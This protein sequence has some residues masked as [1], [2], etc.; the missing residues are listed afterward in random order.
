M[1]NE[2]D[3]D[4]IVSLCGSNTITTTSAITVNQ[5]GMTLCC[6]SED[7]VVE[8]T[9]DD[10]N[11]L[12]T[13]DNFTLS[14]VDF[15]GGNTQEG[16]GGGNV[17]ILANGTHAILECTFDGGRHQFSGGNLFIRTS[18]SVLI[19]NSLFL[20][21]DAQAGGG[22]YVEDA[23]QVVVTDS[24]FSN[25][26]AMSTGG[27]GILTT[28]AIPRSIGQS[29]TLYN[30]SFRENT[31]SFGGGYLQ[32]GIGELPK[33]TILESQ[34]EDNEA[35]EGA[36]AGIFL[37]NELDTLDLTLCGNGGSGNVAENACDDMLFYLEDVNRSCIGVK[38]DF[39]SSSV[40]ERETTT[41][42]PTETNTTTNGARE[43][44]TTIQTGTDTTPTGG[45]E[46]TISTSNSGGTITST[47]DGN[48]TSTRTEKSKSATTTT[49]F[50]GVSSATSG[51]SNSTTGTT[52][53][54]GLRGST[55]T[56]NSGGEPTTTALRGSTTTSPSSDSLSLGTSV[57]SSRFVNTRARVAGVFG[58]PHIVTFD[59]LKF[60]CQA[61]GQFVMLKSLE[62][63]FQIQEKFT[64]VNTT[65]AQASVS[66]GFVVKADDMPLI[67][68]SLLREDG[69]FTN[70][71]GCH[72]ILRQ[73]RSVLSLLVKNES[74]TEP[75][76]GGAFI[77]MDID[78]NEVGVE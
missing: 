55:T 58:D 44:S 74:F 31:A 66:T 75:I 77:N 6:E 20:N 70:I 19:Q 61:E 28:L 23:L 42:D 48:T 49:G 25:N 43:A 5:T 24:V 41:A 36:A 14:N 40:S 26:T 27:G 78:E 10:R 22:L 50:R 53:T 59:G 30:T 29:I 54:T 8:S 64:S 4:S 37:Y 1:V 3:S 51:E 33:L 76:F 16:R 21:G 15:R 63:D 35:F 9:G 69:G 57:S 46:T 13:G 56:T 62:S 73:D 67:E 34:F 45:T 72:V 39:N 2:A 18:D 47:T 17:E 11:L 7:C 12:V 68:I 71:N 52:T 60:D 65:C 32:T 38:E